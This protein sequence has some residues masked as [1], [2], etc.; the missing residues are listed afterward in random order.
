MFSFAKNIFILLFIVIAESGFSQVTISNWVIGNA[1]GHFD[2]GNFQISSTV[3]ESAVNTISFGGII[4]TQ[5]FHQPSVAGGT[6]LIN[7]TSKDANCL[8]SKNGE[9]NATLVNGTPPYSYSWSPEGGNS[10]SA[11]GLSPGTYFLFVVD[12]LGREGRDTV[13]IGALADDACEIHIYGGITPNGDGKNDDWHIDGITIF[14]DNIVT[15][16]NRWGGKVW[17]AKGYDNS[18]KV[19]KGHDLNGDRLPDGTYFYIVEIPGTETYKGWVQ[20]TR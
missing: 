11:T 15:I 16:Y 19:F 1:G 18:E 3:G 2:N 13:T 7:I 12:A 14:S 5:G 17:H 10:S 9:A 20:I 6:L 8:T 4:L